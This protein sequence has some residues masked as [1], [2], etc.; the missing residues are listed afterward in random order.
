[1]I[2]LIEFK[3]HFRNFIFHRVMALD[4]EIGFGEINRSCFSDQKTNFDMRRL[5]QNERLRA[6][7]MLQ[8]GTTQA[9][10]ARTM[11]VSQSVISRLW[12]RYRDTQS[13][14]AQVDQG[15]QLKPTIDLAVPWP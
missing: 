13:D 15:R 14:H 2:L 10:V 6:L 8:I 12:S 5:T 1:M 7:G 9:V 3:S 11:N 4:S